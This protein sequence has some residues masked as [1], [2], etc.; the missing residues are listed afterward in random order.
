MLLPKIE[1]TTR[2][3]ISW[4]RER[5]ERGLEAPLENVILRTGR[6]QTRHKRGILKLLPVTFSNHVDSFL[7]MADDL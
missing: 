1:A 6:G 5:A 7:V 4:L 2:G 3:S